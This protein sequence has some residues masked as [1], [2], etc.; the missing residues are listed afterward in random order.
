M[1]AQVVALAILSQPAPIPMTYG[2][3][4]CSSWPLSR[5]QLADDGIRVQS[6]HLRAG[7]VTAHLLHP[8]AGRR[9]HLVAHRIGSR[10]A[11]WSVWSIRGPSRVTALIAASP[12]CRVT[13]TYAQVMGWPTAA[14]DWLTARST[15]YGSATWRGRVYSVWPCIWS[16]ERAGQGSITNLAGIGPGVMAGGSGAVAAGIEN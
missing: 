2:I 14:R 5:A 10:E 7:R 16:T 9:A 3:A 8:T 11:G 1:I 12:A 15:C 6:V 4:E 13:A